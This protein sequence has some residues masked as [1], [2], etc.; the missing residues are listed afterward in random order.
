MATLHDR[1]I[2]SFQLESRKLVGAVECGSLAI[3]DII[4]ITKFCDSRIAH[5][6][7]PLNAAFNLAHSVD[8]LA[9][10]VGQLAV[11]NEEIEVIWHIYL[12]ALIDGIA[13]F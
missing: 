7:S 2:A 8:Q 13:K 4:L 11:R 12:D 1:S 6:P 9:T 10:H 3:G 5:Y